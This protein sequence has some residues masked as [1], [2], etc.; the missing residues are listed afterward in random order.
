M[1]YVLIQGC[2]TDNKLYLNYN[3]KIENSINF[4]FKQFDLCTFYSQSIV[5]HKL[6]FCIKIKNTK[7][8]QS[9]F[10]NISYIMNKL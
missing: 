1:L 2:F 5:K 3:N 4:L 7:L 6:S 9:N 10:N 8:Y